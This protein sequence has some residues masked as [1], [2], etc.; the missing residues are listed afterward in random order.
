[1]N[2]MIIY[3]EWIKTRWALLAIVVVLLGATALTLL[4]LGKNVEFRGAGLLWSVLS[5]KDTV[6][7]ESLRYLPVFAGAMLAAA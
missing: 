4:S 6:L 5:L 1:M 2:R 7:I 3:K